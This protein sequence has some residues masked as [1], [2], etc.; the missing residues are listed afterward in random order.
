M[1]YDEAYKA[2]I[3]HTA[4]TVVRQAA[5]PVQATAASQL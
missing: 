1:P 4:Y 5:K 3:K 2:A